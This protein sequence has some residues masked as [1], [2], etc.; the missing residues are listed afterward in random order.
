MKKKKPQIQ[1]TVPYEECR[2]AVVMHE[3]TRLWYIHDL[4]SN[5]VYFLKVFDNVQLKHDLRWATYTKNMMGGQKRTETQ[6]WKG[7]LAL[8]THAVCA[9][10]K[11]LSVRRAAKYLKTQDKS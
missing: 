2:K 7:Y 1:A 9:H 6:G 4:S 10:N 5:G 3:C 11:L 8:G